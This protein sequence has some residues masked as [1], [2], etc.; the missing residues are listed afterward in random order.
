M[1]QDLEDYALKGKEITTFHLRQVQERG[2]RQSMMVHCLIQVLNRKEMGG[3]VLQTTIWE[4]RLCISVL[5]IKQFHFVLPSDWINW[6]YS[7]L[8]G[9]GESLDSTSFKRRMFCKFAMDQ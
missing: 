6:M 3:M 4:N 2:L 5:V 8:T 1:L 7:S 9:P